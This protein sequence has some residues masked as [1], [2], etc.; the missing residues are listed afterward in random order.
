MESR[1]NKGFTLIEVLITIAIVSTAIIFIFRSFV[2]LLASQRLAQD[3]I[4]A[5][6]L[7]EEKIFEISAIQKNSASVTRFQEGAATLQQSQFDWNCSLSDSA[8]QGLLLLDFKVFLPSKNSRE[9]SM[10]NFLA[11]IPAQS[12]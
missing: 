7:A 11:L 12:Q 8:D 2:T 9:K 6:F 4:T 10:L 3:M 1:S 5:T